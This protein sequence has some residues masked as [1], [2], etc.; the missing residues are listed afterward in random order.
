MYSHN[1][2]SLGPRA[3]CPDDAKSITRNIRNLDIAAPIRTKFIYSNIMYTAATYL[4]EKMTGLSF[5]DYLDTRFFQPLGMASTSLQPSLAR[6]RGFADR[7]ATGYEWDKK[8]AAY[9][10]L[11]PMESTEAQGAGSVITSAK[12]YIQWVKAL[13]HQEGP[14]NKEVYQGILKQRIFKNPDAQNVFPFSSPDVCCSG[15]N[16]LYY[17][18][19]AVYGHSGGMPGFGSYHFF[20]P[21]FKFGGAIFG[22]SMVNGFV[23]VILAFELIDDLLK[24]PEAERQDWEKAIL[25]GGDD[26]DPEDEEKSKQAAREKICP[27][28]KDPE[29]Q[30]TPLEAYT[31]TYWN[32]GYHHLTVEIRDDNLF[33]DA[34]DR[35][36]AGLFRFEHVCEQTK[37]LVRVTAS[38]EFGSL[39]VGFK[40]AE[41]KMEGDRVVAMGLDLV[42]DL[43]KLIWFEKKG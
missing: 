12:D 10:S 14:I 37:Y 2:A 31:G 22:N 39:E 6:K 7:I 11:Q 41:F 23:A 27:G 30:T 24:V 28:I 1:F 35:S 5:S 38:E 18:G 43:D 21:E 34:S 36:F 25:G 20:V 26:D 13:M 19:Y 4:V 33:V 8:K 42:P 40:Q 9:N 29:P 3:E 32:R 16:S 15:L 17:R